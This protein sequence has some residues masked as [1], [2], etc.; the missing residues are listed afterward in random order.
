MKRSGISDTSTTLTGLQS[1][2]TYYVWVAAEIRGAGVQGPYSDYQDL[3][4]TYA[5]TGVCRDIAIYTYICRYVYL[6]FIAP[7]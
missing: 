4:V 3:W 6:I 2:A 7:S 1:C 5:G